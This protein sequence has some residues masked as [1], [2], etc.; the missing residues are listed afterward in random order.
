MPDFCIA[1]IDFS[2]AISSYKLDIPILMKGK[3]GIPPD[4]QGVVLRGRF[5][6]MPGRLAMPNI[7]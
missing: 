3:Q 5:L 6:V 2:T 7:S 4:P 1:M